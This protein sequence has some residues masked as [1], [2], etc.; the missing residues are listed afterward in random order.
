MTATKTR[1]PS[2]DLI[3]DGPVL[4]RDTHDL[5]LARRL[6]AE[7]LAR[8]YGESV[9]PDDLGPATA[10]WA[11]VFSWCPCGD[12]HAWHHDRAPESARGAFRAV[13]VER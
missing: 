4:V 6:A 5:D 2:A 12:E 8:E 1:E 11:R 7:E 3:A 9:D 10:I 13:E